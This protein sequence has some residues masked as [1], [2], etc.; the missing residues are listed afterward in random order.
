MVLKL[1][2]LFR[3]F[4]YRRLTPIIPRQLE[5]C[6]HTKPSLAN[7]NDDVILLVVEH[8]YHIEPQGIDDLALVCSALYCK[9][10]YVQHRDISIDLWGHYTVQRLQLIEQNGLL[11]AIRTLHVDV[12]RHI[13]RFAGFSHHTYITKC[14][15]EYLEG[16]ATAWAKLC[17]LVTLAQGLRDV[18]W[19][20]PTISPGILEHLRRNPK[21]RL[22]L[23]FNVPTGHFERRELLK[24]LPASLEGTANLR[25][26]RATIMYPEARFCESITR[27]TLKKLLLSSPSLRVLSLDISR[28]GGR[29]MYYDELDYCGVGLSGGETLPPLE[30]LEVI[31]YPWGQ[32]PNDS[33]SGINW[34]GYPDRTGK[35]M[36]YWA[37]TLDWS[38]LRRLCLHDN[39]V[40]L[41]A[42]LAPQL[43]ALQEIDFTFRSCDDVDVAIFFNTISSIL[44]SISLPLLPPNGVSAIIAHSSKLRSLSLNV[45]PPT[46]QDLALLRDG[47][48]FLK[49]LAVA[50]TRVAG[51]WPYDTLSVLASF[52][53][54]RSLTIWFSVGTMH[55]QEKPHLTIS[56]AGNLFTHLRQNGASGL[57][58][59]ILHSG[60]GIWSR[61]RYYGVD[62]LRWM[63][64]NSTS[65]SLEVGYDDVEVSCTSLN[66]LQNERLR[67]VARGE[68]MTK[69]EEESLPFLIAL[70]G[71][72]T[73]TEWCK[74]QGIGLLK[75]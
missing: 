68:P 24:Q 42:H 27:V 52:Q 51:K 73:M 49:D 63:P 62:N 34:R 23:S 26:L 7:L 35:E 29:Y 57:R 54:L 20:G 72:M 2:N 5:P 18:Y 11:P 40:P 45:F 9:A 15:K 69:G 39:S 75:S 60:P 12:N 71:P 58:R 59:L 3:R 65:F 36:E 48:P 37:R 25:S 56:S 28:P 38:K 53:S 33:G 6:D 50:C 1:K 16:Q 10:R 74:W 17:D 8:L 13:E 61:P 14:D 55:D 32:Q 19:D 4:Y 21:L 46:N 47:L 67:R 31:S 30:E 41:A 44:T 70:R 22:H 64:A 66:S 43:T